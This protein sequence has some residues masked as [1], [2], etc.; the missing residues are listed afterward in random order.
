MWHVYIVECRDGTL[1]TGTTTDVIRRVACHNG[2]TGARYTRA[3]RPVRLVY[4][5]TQPTQSAALKREV[6]I[7]RWPRTRKQ[8]L[9]DGQ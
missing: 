3:R 5:E 4:H 8:A 2:K 9:I 7:K 1:Y 6:L